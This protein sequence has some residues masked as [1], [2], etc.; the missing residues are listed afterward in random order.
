MTMQAKT[1]TA[2]LRDAVPVRFMESG[3]EKARYKNIDIP[4]SLKE[5]EIR[6]FAFDV[7]TDGKITFQLFFDEGILPT[8]FPA[9]REKVTRAAKAKEIKREDLAATAAEA[10]EATTG[11][12][13]IVNIPTP[14][15]VLKVMT[16]KGDK[17]EG[18]Y[19]KISDRMLR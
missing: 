2:K 11:S 9:A 19:G 1:I 5:L 4:D 6:D 18:E 12:E 8:E 14:T 10:I 17:M 7:V 16:D 3:E 13:V 15:D